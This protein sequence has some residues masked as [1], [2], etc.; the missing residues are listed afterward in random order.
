MKI[1]TLSKTSD[2]FHIRQVGTYY[3]VNWGMEIIKDNEGADT[4]LCT[5]WQCAFDHK[6]SLV[7]IKNFILGEI[8]AEIDE[9]IMKGFTWRSP[10]GRD[11]NVWLSTENQFNYKV[12]YDLAVQTQGSSLPFILKFGDVDNPEYYTFSDLAV[13][14]DFYAQSIRHING[15][16]HDGWA[17]KDAIDW[18]NYII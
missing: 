8:N 16:I 1:K 13:F 18:G 17:K 5:Y 10:D 3:V 9:K 12:I 14:G 2:F 6:P 11:I 4:D 15:C 7:E